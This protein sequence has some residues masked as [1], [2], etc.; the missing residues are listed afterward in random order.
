MPSW[1]ATQ[2]RGAAARAVA[3]R[4]H[5]G[6]GPGAGLLRLPDDLAERA[7]HQRSP[8]GALGI[9]ERSTGEILPHEQTLPKA[10][11]D[12]L[13]L[14]RATEANLSPIW[15]LSLSAGLTKTFVRDGP[16][17]AVATDDDQVRHELWM[18][19]EPRSSV[20]C[21]RRWEPPRW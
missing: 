20:P 1:I 3:R 21:R 9:D 16:P 17:D 8:I 15:G 4:G 5:P 12:R 13:E 7:R 6:P 18:I 11:S 10:K 19:K 2:E 14:M